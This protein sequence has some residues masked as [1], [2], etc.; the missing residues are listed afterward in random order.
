MRVLNFWLNTVVN[1]STNSRITGAIYS[2]H[3]FD[4]L[5]KL[6]KELPEK[7]QDAVL[8]DATRV[9][10]RDLLPSI[11]AAAPDHTG[12]QSKAS[13]TY[14]TL[15]SNIRVE[16]L[17][18]TRSRRGIKGWRVVTGDAFWGNFLEFGTRF[19]PC[20]RGG[21]FARLGWF[22]EAVEANGER[23]LVKLS[24][25]LLAGIEKEANKLIKKY[26]L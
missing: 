4:E 13:Q 12:K 26:G 19:I 2:L 20:R 16:F 6:L 23:T 18:W 25:G 3:G 11:R 10:A 7:V 17:R 8:K 21:G 5:D 24:E 9:A 22:K 15:K 1:Y 14:G